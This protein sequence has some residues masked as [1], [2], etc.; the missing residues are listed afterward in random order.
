MH[1]HI[2][3]VGFQGVQRQAEGGQPCPVSYF[4]SCFKGP[5]SSSPW[6]ASLHAVLP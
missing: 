1:T 4:P 2:C 6:R 3:T 5:L